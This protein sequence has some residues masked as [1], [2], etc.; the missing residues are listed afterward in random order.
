MSALWTATDL[1]TATGGNMALPFDAT[2]ISIDT[3]TLLPGDLFI[4]LVG[5]VGD[6]HDHAAAAL[7]KGAAGA[8]VHR[9]PAGMAADAR[10]LVVGDTFEALRALGQAGRARFAGRVIAVTGSVGKTT[11]KE[12]L[13][14]ILSAAGETSAALASL[15]N[16]WGVPL[17][18][19][20]LPA[21]ARFAVVEIGM[22]HAGE[23]LPLAQMAR[24]HV[25]LI[26]TIAA[27]HIGY[28]GSIEAIA[29]EKV[30]IVGGLEPGGVAVL[31][32]DTPM[33]PR[34]LTAAPGARLF[35]LAGSADARLVAAEAD[36]TGTDVTVALGGA[37]LHTRLAAPGA[38][39]AVNACG[40]IL[41]ATVMGVHPACAAAAL[42][43]FAP[44]AGR[45]AR[46]QIAT[47]SGPALLLD[48]SYNASPIAVRAA[49]KVLG[50]QRATRRVVV[51]GDMRELGD[52]GPA[53]HAGLAPDIAA[54][55]DTVFTCGPLSLHA[56]DALP[57]ALRGAHAPDSAALAPLVASAL[58]A[59]DAVLV[60]GSLGSKMKIVV[61]AI[62]ANG[63]RVEETR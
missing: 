45:G 53:E 33:L 25:V 5:D 26:T 60:K 1:C 52:S 12:M 57:V 10:L 58:R 54:V 63:S 15:N 3:R 11:S 6:G 36:A 48:E 39:M 34:M 35:G 55:A 31:P 61:D 8:M 16:H 32:A 13:R 9:I 47:A 21:G 51:L 23:I 18:L 30:S 56:H 40:A 2:G 4:A 42:T 49:L 41:A 37:V 44:V 62:I 7:D 17:T 46:K 59:G 20:R 24:P 43:G 50:L 27:V 14:A 19:A 38:H 29:D 22:N 28:L